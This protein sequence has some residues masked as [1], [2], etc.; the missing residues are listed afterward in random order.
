MSRLGISVLALGL[1]ACGDPPDAATGF[2]VCGGGTRC[3]AGRCIAIA[4]TPAPDVPEPDDDKRARRGKR[5][6]RA[7]EPEAEGA[8]T[9]QPVSDRHIPAY[10]PNAT[11]VLG[12]G[13]EFT[14]T[15]PRSDA[16]RPAAPVSV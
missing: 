15:L 9:Y 12:E 7:G 11:T 4:D 14:L 3:E 2:G 5:R 8:S 10:D 13:S 16:A 1:A 6:V